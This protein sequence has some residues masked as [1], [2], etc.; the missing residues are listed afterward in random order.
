[1]TVRSDVVVAE[2]DTVERLR[3]LAASLH[4]AGD[5][6]L[7]VVSGLP[8]E[9]ALLASMVAGAKAYLQKPV[10]AD[11]LD[12]TVRAVAAGHTVVDPRCTAWLVDLA[13]RGQRVPVANGL[14]LRQSHVLHLAGAGLSNREIAEVLGVSLD[15]VKTHVRQALKRLGVADRRT[16]ARRL[17]AVLED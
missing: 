7:I 8:A 2:V 14:T 16:A 12:R 3:A 11:L 1:M 17:T 13:L 15:T 6:K 9:V 10:A 4:E 5:A